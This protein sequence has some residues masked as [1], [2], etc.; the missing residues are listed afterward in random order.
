MDHPLNFPN[1]KQLLP[2]LTTFLVHFNWI[3]KESEGVMGMNRVAWWQLRCAIIQ[4][5]WE[6]KSKLMTW[7]R[8]PLAHSWSNLG[9]LGQTSIYAN[10][11]IGSFTSSSLNDHF[12][13]SH[14]IKSQYGHCLY[15]LILKF[16]VCTIG[17]NKSSIFTFFVDFD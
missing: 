13:S 17:F 9:F 11:G 3:E 15:I 14:V 5:L 7:L 8:Q 4:T 16:R 12:I 10:H 2:I 1:T 6:S